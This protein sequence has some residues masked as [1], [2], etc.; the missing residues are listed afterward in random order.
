MVDRRPVF[1]GPGEGPSV[2]SLGARFT[3]KLDDVLSDGRFAIVEAL[4]FR[5]TEPPLHIHHREDEAWYILNG[6]MTF[7]VDEEALVAPSGTFVLAP[8]GR[9]HTFTVDVEP[10]RARVRRSRRVRALCAGA[11]HPG[12]IEHSPCRPGGS[13]PRGA[14]ARWRAIRYRGCRAPA[15]HLPPR[16]L[17]RREGSPSTHPT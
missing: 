9:P 8:M 14:G 10:T 4:A 5:S 12:D 15:A 11:R 3:V 17:S 7:Y 13:R 6:Q 1:H 16:H 2:W